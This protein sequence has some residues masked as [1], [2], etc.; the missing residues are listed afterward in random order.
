MAAFANVDLKS[1]ELIEK[2]LMRRL[3]GSDN[4]DLGAWT[5]H[6]YLLGLTIFQIIRGLLHRD[7]PRFI[8]LD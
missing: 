7:A 6:A 1:G 3:S 2:G 8:I 5:T 4:R